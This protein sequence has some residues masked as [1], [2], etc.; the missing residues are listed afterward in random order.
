MK[1]LNR[2]SK[3][4]KKEVLIECKFCEKLFCVKHILP[5][6]HKCIGLDEFKK[7][8]LPKVEKFEDTPLYMSDREELSKFGKIARI[9]AARKR[10]DIDIIKQNGLNISNKVEEKT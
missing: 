6:L 2:C 9:R 7:R 8:K 3:C 1:D 4:R 10:N 5:E